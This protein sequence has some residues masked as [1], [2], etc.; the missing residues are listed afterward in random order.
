MEKQSPQ[1]LKGFRDYL[2]DSQ[3]TRQK[4][5][6]KISET[7]ESFG[8]L[9]M[10]TPVLESYDLLGGKAGEEAEQLMY[11]FQDQGEREVAMRYDLTVPLARVMANNQNL[12]KPFKRYQMGLVWRADK[13]Q[14]GRYR[15]FMQCDVD[16]LG[17]SSVNAEVD[18]AAA[19]DAAYKNLGLNNV[20][21]KFN[22]REFVD[23]ALKTLKISGER[24]V[25]FMRTMDKMDKIGEG[26]VLEILE[27]AGFGSDILRAYSKI[28]DDISG[29]YVKQMKSLLIQVGIANAEFD[30]YLVRGLD[31]YTGV[32]FEYFLPDKPEF[33]SIGSGGRYDKM[34]GQISGTDM[35]AVGTSIG[36]DR[37]LAAMADMGLMETELGTQ[38]LV[39]NLD[40]GLINDY[41]GIVRDLREAG[42][43]TD[44]YYESAKIDKQFKYAESLGIP[45]AV[46]VGPDEIRDK[47]VN[48]KDLKKKK[49][50]RVDLKNLVDEVKILVK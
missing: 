30:K 12:P 24:K 26:K 15:E 8:F 39:M 46:I 34:I 35:P 25:A 45:Y 3:M 48:I 31:Y 17:S 1:I 44:F 42:I 50:T 32:V 36:L 33:G 14:K 20:V 47:Q 19:V 27:E 22:N 29:D 13:P 11:K 4:V 16:V 37:M 28:M 6:K 23:Q 49:E 9:P 10:D 7:F 21:L 43:R 2:P 40:D 5:L 18:C 41:F 38:V